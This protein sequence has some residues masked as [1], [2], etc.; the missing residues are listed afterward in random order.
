VVPE[1]NKKTDRVDLRIS[2][3]EKA[4]FERAARAKGLNL[5]AYIVSTVSMDARETIEREHLVLLTNQSARTFL[6]ALEAE[7]NAKLT[8]AAE[9]FDRLSS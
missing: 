6:D 1:E 7:P 4:L 8:R 5:T 3:R 2:P 9:K